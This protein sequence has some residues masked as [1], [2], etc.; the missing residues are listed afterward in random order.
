MALRPTCRSKRGPIRSLAS[1]PFSGVVYVFQA[2]RQGEAAV[3]G[4]IKRLEGAKFGGLSGSGQATRRI[5][6][7]AVVGAGR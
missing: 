6:V 7:V 2:L 4:G 3:L 5:G 1:S